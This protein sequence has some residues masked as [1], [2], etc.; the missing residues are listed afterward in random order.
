MLVAL[1]CDRVALALRHH[2]RGDL[3]LQPAV[4]DR[5]GRTA[6][7]AVGVG[8]LVASLDLVF[9]G[10]VLGRLRHR[11]DPVLRLHQLVDETPA[12]R[13]V[14]DLGR[15]GVRGL[16]LG[17]DE[18]RAGHALDA[19]GDGEFRLARLDRTSRAADRI[20]AGAAE[21]VDGDARHRLGQAREQR[22]HAG[23]VAVVLAR[24]VGAAELDVVHP[25]PVDAR[26][27]RHQRGDGHCAEIVG[28]NGGERTAEAPDGGP[29]SVADEG[30]GHGLRLPSS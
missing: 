13:G 9:L 2:D 28:P 7:A 5:L 24:L 1:D 22:R 29:L 21:P 10:N 14:L 20:H 6:L 18:G 23:D 30:L 25:R 16:G 26:V 15:A 8:I 11:I 17:H 12:E 4:L 27:A 19:A 3:A